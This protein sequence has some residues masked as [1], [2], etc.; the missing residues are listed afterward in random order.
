MRGHRANTRGHS[1]TT[2][3]CVLLDQRLKPAPGYRSNQLAA[4]SA[5]YLTSV[6]A[7]DVDVQDARLSEWADHESRSVP[8]DHDQHLAFDETGLT[9][10]LRARR[11]TRVWVGGLALDVC[12]RAMKHSQG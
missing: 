4:R 3:P 11:I 1:I 7:A 5:T 2:P 8:L 10:D 9:V 12:V 6:H